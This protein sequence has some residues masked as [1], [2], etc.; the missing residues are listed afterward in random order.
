[1]GCAV[2]T[3]KFVV[4]IF[5]FLLVCLGFAMILFGAMEGPMPD[6]FEKIPEMAQDYSITSKVLII[7]GS[8]IFVVAFFGCWGAVSD[9]SCML[10]L[11]AVF[12]MVLILVEAA[13]GVYVYVH[14]DT[15]RQKV[16]ADLKHWITE[17]NTQPP[18]NAKAIID[19]LQTGLRCCGVESPRDWE[20]NR[21][22]IPKSCCKEDLTV[23]NLQNAYPYG[24]LKVGLDLVNSK[25]KKYLI[26]VGGI[27]GVEVLT[28]IFALIVRNSILNEKRRSL[29]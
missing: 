21:T 17:Y 28:I 11:Y 16:S 13:V 5:N 22:P 8:I 12:L 6:E 14:K 10:F 20:Q 29:A 15:I 24:C 25:L 23:C 2:G 9:S 18:T 26:I 7:A 1:M 19:K 3:V 27:V 4:F